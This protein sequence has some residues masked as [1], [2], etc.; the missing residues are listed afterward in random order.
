MQNVHRNT[1][2]HVAGQHTI[3]GRFRPSRSA[4][5]RPSAAHPS[6]EF[7]EQRRRCRST[8]VGLMP[9][10]VRASSSPPASA[11]AAWFSRPPF[12]QPR[13]VGRQRSHCGV[14]CGCMLDVTV[15]EDS[16]QQP[17]QVSTKPF[18]RGRP[19]ALQRPLR[20][21]VVAEARPA[22]SWE[23]GVRK[24]VINDS[25]NARNL[26]EPSQVIVR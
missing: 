26:G 15:V 23:S 17:A 7:A 11:Y 24:S 3:A 20:R 2:Y 22:V 19:C 25:D 8:P 14:K 21:E 12:R 16:V 4:A 6:A 13:C 1:T 18:Q 9:V 5:A 10:V